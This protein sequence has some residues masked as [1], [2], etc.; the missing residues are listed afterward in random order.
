MLVMRIRI[1]K[2]AFELTSKSSRLNYVLVLFKPYANANR[3]TEA[4]QNQWHEI[5]KLTHLIYNII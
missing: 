5:E 1:A 2:S 3:R 4:R